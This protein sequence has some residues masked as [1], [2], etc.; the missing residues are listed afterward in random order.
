MKLEKLLHLYLDAK[1]MEVLTL[2]AM[3]GHQ[4]LGWRLRWVFMPAVVTL[5][6]AIPFIFAP[7]FK[8]LA[9]AVKSQA[10]GGKK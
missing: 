3:A 4:I 2:I 1:G 5:I 7:T 8:R 6:I 9:L 10:A